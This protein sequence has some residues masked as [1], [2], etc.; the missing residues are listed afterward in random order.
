MINKAEQ[1]A[2]SSGLAYLEATAR[3][4][5]QGDLSIARLLVEEAIRLS[6]DIAGLG[7]KEKLLGL[8]AH[9]YRH[10][11]IENDDDVPFPDCDY[12]YAGT[13]TDG[14]LTVVD[15]SRTNIVH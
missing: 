15:A 1:F 9:I 5:E 3:F 8:S 6:G 14:R 13:G 12:Y 2:A 4:M 11:H 10:E 7:F